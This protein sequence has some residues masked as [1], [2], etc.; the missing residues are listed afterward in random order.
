[1][2]KCPVDWS[3]LLSS[4]DLPSHTNEPCTVLPGTHT[5]HIGRPSRCLLASAGPVTIASNC[6]GCLNDLHLVKLLQS[7]A[8]ICMS[9]QTF[10]ETT[11]FVQICPRALTGI[12]SAPTPRQILLHV[13]PISPDRPLICKPAIASLFVDTLITRACLKADRRGVTGT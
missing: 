3:E 10:A 8:V 5:S 12:V 4:A 7:T 2:G 6:V 11:G 13:W 1:M 9:L